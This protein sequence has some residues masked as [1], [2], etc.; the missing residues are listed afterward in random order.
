MFDYIAVCGHFEI[1]R[2]EIYM[3]LGLRFFFF[4]ERLYFDKSK[5]PLLCQSHFASLRAMSRRCKYQLPT[6]TKQITLPKEALK[7]IF[8]PYINRKNFNHFALAIDLFTIAPLIILHASHV[9]SFRI[10][11]RK[12]N[13]QN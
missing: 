1:D 8:F 6:H 3:S 7:I 9:I 13:I 10:S 12:K 11:E 5:Q 4:K 2:P